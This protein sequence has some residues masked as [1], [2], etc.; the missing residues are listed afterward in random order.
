MSIQNKINLAFLL[1]LRENWPAS[2][3]DYRKLPFYLFPQLGSLF[4]LLLIALGGLWIVSEKHVLLDQVAEVAN[5]PYMAI[6]FDGYMYGSEGG[7]RLGSDDPHDPAY[8]RNMN[9]STLLPESTGEPLGDESVFESVSVYSDGQLSF[10]DSKNRQISGIQGKGLVLDFVNP[11]RRNER[12]LDGL[13]EIAGGSWRWTDHRNVNGIIMSAQLMETLGYTKP[14]PRTLKL[15]YDHWGQNDPMAYVFFP[16]VVLDELP[17]RK[18]IVPRR[19]YNR[20]ESGFY[21]QT[22]E[23]VRILFSADEET[24]TQALARLDKAFPHGTVEGM[25]RYSNRYCTWLSFPGLAK[26]RMDILADFV[27]QHQNIGQVY[28]D[29][30]GEPEELSRYNGAMLYLN[31]KLV[32]TDSVQSR[33]IPSLRGFINKLVDQEVHSEILEVLSTVLSNQTMLLRL[34]NQFNRTTF[35]LA[36]ILT[37]YNAVVLHSRVHRIGVLREQGASAKLFVKIFLI[38]SLFVTLVAFGLALLIH[39]LSSQGLS[40]SQLIGSPQV[41]GLLG[42]LSLAATV[43]YVVPVIVYI[44]LM[45]P[46]EMVSYRTG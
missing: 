42:R 12:L 38:Q 3:G 41:Y 22:V 33:L 31:R 13:R 4:I 1:L 27:S 14:W 40:M 39:G 45:E 17:Y 23:S 37:L 19:I 18:F 6:F 15:Q 44:N 24:S 36:V 5:S 7:T 20:L 26:G 35:A 28:F 8:W 9:L 2:D 25:Q 43:G 46:A 34:S 10:L 32:Q 21:M 16:V 29:G 11:E 30:D